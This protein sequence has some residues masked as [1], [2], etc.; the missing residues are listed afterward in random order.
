[1]KFGVVTEMSTFLAITQV[2]SG[3]K[4]S[5][6]LIFSK[7][8][9]LHVKIANLA[10][11]LGIRIRSVYA[12][13][14]HFQDLWTN[15]CGLVGVARAFGTVGHACM[16][17]EVWKVWEFKEG[18]MYVFRWKSSRRWARFQTAQNAKI[19][20]SLKTTTRFICFARRCVSLSY[21]SFST[22]ILRRWSCI[23]ALSSP[24]S[25]QVPS[26]S[27]LW[28]PFAILTSWQWDR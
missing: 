14:T 2:S 16:C 15:T 21:S 22:R 25:R 28:S 23:Y 1:M 17:N 24:F 4:T 19:W 7:Y 9:Y 11:V 18:K 27:S 26:F 3:L 13:R 12:P 20:S 8:K 6:I 5:H 10:N